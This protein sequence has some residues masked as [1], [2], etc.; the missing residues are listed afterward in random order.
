MQYY[1]SDFEQVF[2]HWDITQWVHNQAQGRKKDKYN[3]RFRLCLLR[4]IN[5]MHKS[6]CVCVHLTRCPQ[7]FEPPHLWALSPTWANPL[8]RHPPTPT[9]AQSIKPPGDAGC[10]CW[11]SMHRYYAYNKYFAN[12]LTTLSLYKNSFITTFLAK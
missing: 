6:F 9:V 1:F 11:S 4:E 5:A 10:P 3:H 8:P 2:S 7:M 12:K